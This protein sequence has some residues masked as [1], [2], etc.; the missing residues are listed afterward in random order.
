MLFDGAPDPADGGLTPDLARPGLGLEF[1]AA[2]AE[3]YRT[4]PRANDNG[5][6]LMS[7]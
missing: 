6:P 4:G 3:R 5:G 7:L 2:D 1:R